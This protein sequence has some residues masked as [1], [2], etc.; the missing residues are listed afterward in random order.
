M[1]V[2]RKCLHCDTVAYAEAE[3]EVF[4]KGSGNYKHGRRNICK[5]CEYARKSKVY[6]MSEE[7]RAITVARSR[8]CRINK[9]TKA[10]ILK[11]GCCTSCEI[12]FNGANH[13]IFDFHHIEPETKPKSYKGLL[14]KKWE[15]IEQELA[16]CVLVCSNCHRLIHSKGY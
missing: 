10:I 16:L 5:P 1:E 2:L 6:S 7:V 12:P 15:S 4:V 8:M 11:G 13:A 9:K 3:L 14:D